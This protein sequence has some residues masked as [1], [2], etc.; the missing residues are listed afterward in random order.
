[1]QRLSSSLRSRSAE[2]S[3]IL[4]QQIAP[5]LGITRVTDTTWLD[6]IGIPVFASIRPD[7]LAPTLCVHAGKGARTAEAKIGAYMEA[8]EFAVADPRRHADRIVA[9][10]VREISQSFGNTFPFTWFCARWGEDIQP[11]D[12]V[13]AMEA[14]EQF[15]GRTVWVPAEL[16]LHPYVPKDRRPIFDGSTN[17]LC[18]GN[19]ADE[20]LLHGVCEVLERD[21]Y[22]MELVQDRSLRVDL[23]DATTII[24]D[25]QAKILDAG[26]TLAVR[27]SAN[28]YGMAFISAYVM[29]PE[30]TDAIAIAK[31]MGFHP[32]AEIA[33]VRA[34]S[35][36]VQA[37]LSHI[38]GGRDDIIERVRHFERRG[39]EAEIAINRQVRAKVSDLSQSIR[40]S[41]L[42]DYSRKINSLT[43]ALALLKFAMQAEGLHW[44]AVTR[45]SEDQFPFTVLRVIVPGAESFNPPRRRVGPRLL[46]AF[47]SSDYARDHRPETE[48]VCTP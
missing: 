42:P 36:A 20:A 40:F 35:E 18:S 22:S 37:R 32:I 27:Y 25:T 11:T 2:D 43:E 13:P 14:V 45:L 47:L 39:R 48:S 19:T 1:M 31:G 46:K 7:A 10:T 44:C 3:L 4:A 23:S 8:I 24:Q 9:K 28:A 12:Q 41:C 33:T 15:S 17:G 6:R 30:D 29:E 5:A 16:V 26:L 34:I 38:H 21:V